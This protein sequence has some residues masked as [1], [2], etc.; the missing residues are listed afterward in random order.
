MMKYLR[1][2]VIILSVLVCFITLI[3]G[4]SHAASMLLESKHDL[5]SQGTSNFQFWTLRV[6]VF[7]H[8]PHGANT[9]VRERTLINADNPSAAYLNTG[10]PIATTGP[11][12]LLWNRVLSNA[13]QYGYGFNS[14]QSSTMNSNN[15]TVRVYSLL[16]LSCHDG[17]GALNVLY[18][19]P[20]DATTETET[21]NP[22]KIKIWGGVGDDQIGD[23]Q[24]TAELNPNIGGR[25]SSTNTNFTGDHAVLLDNDH[26][27]SFDYD[28][29]VDSGLKTKTFA[30]GRG[31]RF[32]TNPAG[33]PNISVEC[34]SC[35]NPHYQGAEP[36]GPRWPF[37]V[38]SN[39]GSYM[40]LSCHDK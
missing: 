7:C 34:S 37:L 39:T 6:C 19:T 25:L 4:I 23:Q 11:S 28:T 35:H 36:S 8:T 26:P 32:F 12:I 17:V 20:D 18:S 16:C 24:Y 30:E 38:T 15:S 1:Y 3:S 13:A 21:G 31:I 5:S 9:D 40:C 10:G 27:I 22:Y 33:V 29:S 2:L 14:Y